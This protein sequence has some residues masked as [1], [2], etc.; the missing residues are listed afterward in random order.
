MLKVVFERAKAATYDN[1][2]SVMAVSHI[3][4]EGGREKNYINLYG[5]HDYNEVLKDRIKLNL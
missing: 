3:A 4:N 2:G 1:S 5:T